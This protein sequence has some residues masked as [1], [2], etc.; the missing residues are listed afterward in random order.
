MGVVKAGGAPVVVD[1]RVE[2]DDGSG[3]DCL[4]L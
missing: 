4:E 3:V 1:I 2:S